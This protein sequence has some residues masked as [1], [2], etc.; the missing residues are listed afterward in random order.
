MSGPTPRTSPVAGR[1]GTQHDHRAATR[2]LVLRHGQSEWNAVHRWQGHADIALD[3]VGVSQA[4]RAAEVLGSFDAVWASDLQRAHHTAAII[5]EV[6]GVGPVQVDARLRE[7]HVGPWE[8]LTQAEV[9]AGWPGFLAERRR[10]EGFESYDH[11]AA[12]MAA[13]LHDIADLHP[14]GEVL[15]ISH[16]GTIRA[17]R[18]LLGAHDERLAN[19]AGSWFTGHA[20][21]TIHPGDLVA[22]LAA[23]QAADDVL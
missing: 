2:L 1:G 13:A 10:P 8:G 15:V 23:A 21:G 12:R 19:L 14:G 22:P 9:E 16:G 5:A 7:T 18:R 3:E 17:L 20:D 6:I 4:R 11:A